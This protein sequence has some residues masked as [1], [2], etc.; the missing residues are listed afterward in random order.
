MFVC[1]SVCMLVEAR[2]EGFR[3]PGVGVAGICV[4]LTWV[5]E[6]DLGNSRTLSSQ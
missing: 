5:L 6:T 3:P 4:P 1:L 2:K